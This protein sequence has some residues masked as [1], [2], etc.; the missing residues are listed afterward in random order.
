M[1]LGNAVDCP[2]AATTQPKMH[3]AR[4][5]DITAQKQRALF[6]FAFDAGSPRKDTPEGDNVGFDEQVDIHAR[7][8]RA[9]LGQVGTGLYFEPVS[10]VRRRFAFEMKADDDAPPG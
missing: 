10:R 1:Q 4:K 2:I 5:A 9:D 6:N 8:R 7:I 3:G